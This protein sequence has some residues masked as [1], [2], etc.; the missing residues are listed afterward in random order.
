[1]NPR[2]NAIIVCVLKEAP[3]SAN[4]SY[5]SSTKYQKAMLCLIISGIR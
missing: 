1:M 5:F 3:I 4:A 2:A